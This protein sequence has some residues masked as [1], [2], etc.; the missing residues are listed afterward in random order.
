MVS[1]RRIFNCN[2]NSINLIPNL[3]SMISFTCNSLFEIS[4]LVSKTQIWIF[5]WVNLTSQ[6]L[7]FLVLLFIHHP[8][9]C[10]LILKRSNFMLSV[11]SQNSQIILFMSQSRNCVKISIR[12]SSCI[13]LNQSLFIVKNCTLMISLFDLVHENVVVSISLSQLEVFSFEFRDKEIFLVWLETGR[14]V[15]LI[16]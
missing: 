14:I 4:H 2:S 7:Y 8:N 3:I 16:D 10:N 15:I 13:F 11:N 5:S 1:S 9:S 6:F 12:S